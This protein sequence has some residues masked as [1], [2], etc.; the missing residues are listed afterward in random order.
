MFVQFNSGEVRPVT[1]CCWRKVPVQRSMP[2]KKYGEPP[3]NAAVVL[4]ADQLLEIGRPWNA[5]TFTL[6][7]ASGE[8]LG[9]L[10][11]RT[12]GGRLAQMLGG[13]PVVAPANSRTNALHKLVQRR[14][15]RD[16]F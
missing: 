2:K 13:I 8:Q 16:A 1:N 12:V 6:V 5:E 4:P 7:K 3:S 10:C 14:Q 9:R 11:D 15:S